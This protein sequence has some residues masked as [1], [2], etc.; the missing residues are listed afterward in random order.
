[1]GYFAHI[2]LPMPTTATLIAIVMEFFA[3][4]AIVLGI[5]TRP[6]A[7]LLAPYTIATGFPGHPYWAMTGA[8]QAGAVINFYKNISIVGGLLLLYESGPGKFAVDAR[9]GLA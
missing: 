6:I 4:L 7:L 1:V 3:G 5:L 2:D 9:I 8:E